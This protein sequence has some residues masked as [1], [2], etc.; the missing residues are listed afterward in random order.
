MIDVFVV[1]VSAWQ[2]GTV[3]NCS[4]WPW[5]M[6]VNVG[7]M[8][9]SAFLIEVVFLWRFGLVVVC[10]VVFCKVFNDCG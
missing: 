9:P 2:C 4:A 8:E 10:G 7:F 5:F 1:R 3:R 6:L